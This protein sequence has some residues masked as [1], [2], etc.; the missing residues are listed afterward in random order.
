MKKV[1]IIGAG[2]TGLS[3]AL[4]WPKR[5]ASV[6]G[7]DVLEDNVIVTTPHFQYKRWFDDL[8]LDEIDGTGFVV[9]RKMDTSITAC[10]WTNKKWAHAAP[11]GKTLLRAYVGRPGEYIVQEKDDD[12]IV[13]GY[14]SRIEIDGKP[15]PECYHI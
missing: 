10:T 13:V 8:P 4:N 14:I 5:S 12:D 6:M 15:C 2:I 9:S 3:A 1:A 7:D 11:E